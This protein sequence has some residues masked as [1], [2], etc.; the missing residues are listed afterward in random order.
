M[1]FEYFLSALKT[2]NLARVLAEPNVIVMSGQEANFLAGGEI[3]VPVPQSG[4]GG[5]TTITIEYKQFGVKLNVVPVAL[6]SGRM[7]LKVA[8]E[9]SDLDFSNAVTLSGTQIPAITKRTVNT[10][11][12]LG[13]GQTFAIAGLLNDRVQANRSSTPYLGELPILGALFRSVR[14]ERKETELLVLV[15]PRLVAPLNPDQVPALPGEHWRHPKDGE[16][17]WLQ[18]I[19]SDQPDP[20]KTAGPADASKRATPATATTP[21]AASGDGG[22]AAP[23]R[24]LGDYG[25]APSTQPAASS[26]N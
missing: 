24:F 19:G 6:G 26:S 23:S 14:Y 7:R 13:D 12:E 22:N 21:S 17:Y 16:L 20:K 9:V 5:G 4:S 11:I 25:F 10:T 1:S 8:P 2:N 3:P 18:D 15:T